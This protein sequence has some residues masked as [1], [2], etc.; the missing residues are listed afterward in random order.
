[1]IYL[2][3]KNWKDI[4]IYILFGAICLVLFWRP[5]P[6]NEATLGFKSAD[7]EMRALLQQQTESKEHTAKQQTTKPQTTKP[8]TEPKE[9]DTKPRTGGNEPEYT[10]EPVKKSEPKETAGSKAKINLNQATAQQLDALPGIGASRAQAIVALRQKL[11]GRFQ[12][13]DEL[14]E[15]KGIGDKMLE[16][17]L[18]FVTLAP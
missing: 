5:W 12:S 7:E 14:L 17:L 8:L 18:P 13:V 2:A 15:V 6:P 1:M 3:G 11:G 16:K 9:T 4:T 10:A